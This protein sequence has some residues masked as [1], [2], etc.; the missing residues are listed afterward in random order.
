MSGLNEGQKVE[1]E[2]VQDDRGRT[3]AGNLKASE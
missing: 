1:Y 2:L 3:S